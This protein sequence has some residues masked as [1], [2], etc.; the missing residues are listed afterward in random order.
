[1]HNEPRIHI[2]DDDKAIR[3]SISLLMQA[4]NIPAQTYE[5]AED[6]LYKKGYS[7]LGCLLLDIRMPDMNGM[8]LLELLKKQDI[9]IPVIFM[10]GHGD[11][12]MAVKAMKLG[13][14]D[15]IEKPF[16]NDDLVKIVNN[17]LSDC[18][19]ISNNH[20][21]KIEMKKLIDSLTKREKQVLEQLV[22]GKQNKVIAQVLEISPRTV[23]LHRSRVM[24]KLNAHSLSELVR[25]SL[26]ANGGH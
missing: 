4:E 23:E 16:S 1:M 25:I 2:V 9:S 26:I 10:T 11:V 17:C 24:E 19:T 20:Q 8:E 6:F 3:D 15:F 13:A 21:H 5:S 14:T 7:E 22:N 12:M 18:V